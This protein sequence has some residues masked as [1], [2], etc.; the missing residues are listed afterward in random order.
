MLPTILAAA[1]AVEDDQNQIQDIAHSMLVSQGFFAKAPGN[2]GT[3]ASQAKHTLGYYKDG[4]IN[5]SLPRSCWGCGGNHSWM[6]K[7]KVA[8]P[9][10]SKPQVVKVA[11]E[12]YAAWKVEL[13][14]S[15]GKSKSQKKGKMTIE[16]KDLDKNPRRR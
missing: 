6:Q 7:G 13:K 1:Q 15:G 16:Y 10:G 4:A 12:K 11:A 2:T 5:V 3:Y 9:R 8:C 14:R